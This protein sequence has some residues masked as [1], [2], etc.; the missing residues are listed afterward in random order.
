MSNPCYKCEKRHQACA[1]GCP[2]WAE[3]EQKRADKYEEKK[4]QCEAES[5]VI[6]HIVERKERIRKYW[7]GKK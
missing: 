2:E 5:A 7:N 1:V 4:K 6:G 3:Y